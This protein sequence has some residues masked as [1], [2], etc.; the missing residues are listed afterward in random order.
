MHLRQHGGVALVSLDVVPGPRRDKR[1]RDHQAFV[2]G[3]GELAR[4]AVAARARLVTERQPGS[5]MLDLQPPAQVRHR[6]RPMWHG[7]LEPD[8]VRSAVRRHRNRDRRLMHVQAYKD[9]F[10]IH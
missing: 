7:A 1:R 10:L 2:A 8:L 9:D 3:V 4:Q 5:R 6:T